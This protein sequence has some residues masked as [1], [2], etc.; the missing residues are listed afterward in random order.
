[1]IL[2]LNFTKHYDNEFDAFESNLK[3]TFVGVVIVLTVVKQ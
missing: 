3:K 2:E 1:M